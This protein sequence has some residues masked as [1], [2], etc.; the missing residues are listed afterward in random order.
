MRKT[1]LRILIAAAIASLAAFLVFWFGLRSSGKEPEKLPSLRGEAAIEHLKEKGIYSSLAEA[2]QAARYKVYPTPPSQNSQQGGRFYA[3]NPRQGYQSLF[4]EEEMRLV[5]REGEQTMEW[6]MKLSAC[7]YDERMMTVAQG[8][9]KVAGNRVEIEREVLSRESGVESQIAQVSDSGLQTPDS[10]LIEWYV[11]SDEG[12]E[13]GFKLNCSPGERG[14]KLR[15]MF[16]V[17]GN[18]IA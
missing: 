13:Q 4:S 6:G 2:M 1:H 17:G 14:E 18:L 12:L 8:E 15:L 11:N 5:T 10:R 9:M 16:E 7:G 3:N